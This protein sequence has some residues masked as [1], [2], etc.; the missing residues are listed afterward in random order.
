MLRVSGRPEKVNHSKWFGSSESEEDG[1]SDEKDRKRS[2]GIELCVNFNV[3]EKKNNN[4]TERTVKVP[5][6]R[7]I[8]LCVVQR[9]A[10]PR[11]V[12][13]LR[14]LEVVSPHLGDVPLYKSPVALAF[15]RHLLKEERC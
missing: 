4:K 6:D 1:V 8:R 10:S 3:A 11:S 7:R 12:A 13:A 14:V 9:L 15:P 2:C 5:V